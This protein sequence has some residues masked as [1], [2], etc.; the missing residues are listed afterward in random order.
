MFALEG[1]AVPHSGGNEFRLVIQ[2]QS[3]TIFSAN[4]TELKKFFNNFD[5]GGSAMIAVV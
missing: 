4:K 3:Y 2:V 5:G 1:K